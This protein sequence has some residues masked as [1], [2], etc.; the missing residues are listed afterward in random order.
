LWQ[1]K[2]KKAESFHFLKTTT[3]DNTMSSSDYSDD[4]SDIRSGIVEHKA[5]AFEHKMA[6]DHSHAQAEANWAAAK[7]PELPMT[8]RVKAGTSAIGEKVKEGAHALQRDIDNNL[9]S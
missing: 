3:Q 6:A 4:R 1:A 8:E 9:R 2:V 5:S 7:N